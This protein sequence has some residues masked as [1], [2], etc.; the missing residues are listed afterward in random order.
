MRIIIIFLC[1][2]IITPTY[3]APLPNYDLTVTDGKFMPQEITV[4]SGQRF[5]ITIR[6]TGTTPAEFEN[7][8]LRVEKV[9]GPNIQSFVV[10]HPLKPGNYHFIDEFHLDMKGF[11][12]IA[13]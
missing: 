3:A 8:S 13:K 4:P 1:L 7:L 11:E 2:F 5:K 6:N 9:L 12:I 10:I